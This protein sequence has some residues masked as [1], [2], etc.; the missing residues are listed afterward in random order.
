MLGLHRIENKPGCRHVLGLQQVNPI[1]LSSDL[2]LPF[3][4]LKLLNL[5]GNNR[6]IKNTSRA[7]VTP[8]SILLLLLVDIRFEKN[9]KIR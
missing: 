8:I 3:S 5:F 1:G 2:N 4:F 7:T 9:S 6:N